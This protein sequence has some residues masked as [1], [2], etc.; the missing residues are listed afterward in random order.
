M[1]Y[2]THPYPTR[3]SLAFF[4]PFH[5]RPQ[6]PI[7]NITSVHIAHAQL[8]PTGLRLHRIC[9]YWSVC[10]EQPVPV[11]LPLCP[12][13]SHPPRLVNYVIVKPPN[14]QIFFTPRNLCTLRN[15]SP[16][17]LLFFPLSL[18]LRLLQSSFA[19]APNF[20]PTLFLPPSAHIFSPVRESFFSLSAPLSPLPPSPS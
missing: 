3:H 20:P 17:P 13:I 19:L 5:A 9:L 10:L 16:Y 11:F 7:A 14:I 6:T 18:L 4:S 12:R 15:P 2:R 8:W 1:P